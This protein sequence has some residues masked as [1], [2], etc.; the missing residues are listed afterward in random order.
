MQ[1][2]ESIKRMQNLHELIKKE[3]TGTPCEL[4]YHFCLSRRQLYNIIEDLKIMG[5]DIKYN[6]DRS[7]FYY[8]NG[9]DLRLDFHVSFVNGNNERNIYGGNSNKISYSAILFH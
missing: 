7:T 3:S 5:A 9:F 8:T 6:R 1:W 2:L 4:A